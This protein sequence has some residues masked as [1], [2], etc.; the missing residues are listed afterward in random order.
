[1]T[2]SSILLLA[3]LLS[4]LFALES[5][6]MASVASISWEDTLPVPVLERLARR[7]QLL[8]AVFTESKTDIDA[9]VCESVL[10]CD[11]EIA[12]ESSLIK[13]AMT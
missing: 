6:S 12:A 1:M 13:T 7:S 3:S 11:E 8:V 10:R 5:R 4:S 9:E 2:L